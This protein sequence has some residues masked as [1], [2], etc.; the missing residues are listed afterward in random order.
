MTP[1]LTMVSGAAARGSL[2]RL[3]L[4]SDPADRLL[5]TIELQPHQ[6]SAVS[7]LRK[8]IREFGGALLCDPVGTGKTYIALAL[9][10]RDERTLV[11]APAVLKEMWE[12]AGQ[13]TDRRV[14]FTSF[15][16]L[17]RRRDFIGDYS[18]LIVD[19]A[20]HAR[21]PSTQRYDT[22]SRLASRSDMILLTA[23]PVHNRRKDIEALLGLFMGSRATSLKPAELSRCVIR[24]EAAA[25][26]L[27]GMPHAEPVTWFRIDEHNDIVQMLLSLPLPVP[28]RDGG[29]GGALVINSL[30]R[31]WASSDAALRGGLRRR[32]VRAQSLIASLERGR[33]P[34]K[35]ELTAWIVDDETIQ[36]SFAELLSPATAHSHELLNSVRSHAE[37][38]R[39]LLGA[40][41]TTQADDRRADLIRRLREVHSGRRIVAFSQYADTID[42]MF[43]LLSP[44]GGV[45]ALTGSGARVAG[46]SISRTDA[47]GRF[48]PVASGRPRAR[49][50]NDVSLLLAT[51][52]AQ[53]GR[54]SPGRGSRRSPRPSVDASENGATTR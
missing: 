9:T 2:A 4:E 43:A 33:W 32:L 16:A 34:S 54:Q 10:H 23:T 44:D 30:I 20:H 47:L 38:V 15:E 49:P 12:R 8:A 52:L 50:A 18:F 13:L 6:V 25:E 21:N 48:A 46:G 27:S 51:D 40:A 17:S 36:L 22:L 41:A 26:S 14:A 19:E 7:R 3:I 53:R 31:Q 45:A 24:R 5:G 28:P 42:R 1:G 35:S 37:A 39:E 11:V 29:D